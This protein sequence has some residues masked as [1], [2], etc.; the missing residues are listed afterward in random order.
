M[1]TSTSSR[2]PGNG[3]PL[4]PPWADVD[5]AGPGPAPESDRFR[6]FRTALGR[7][8]GSSDP[9][10]L[11]KALRHYTRSS[12]GGSTVGP[13]RFGAMA[14]V[15]GG[16]FGVLDQLRTN[17]A[18]APVDLRALSGRPTREAIDA[19]VEALV[20]ENGDAERIARLEC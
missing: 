8:V 1:G 5:S 6:G 20:P 14:Q 12:T 17:P 7:Y 18:K 9:S 10:Y 3:S 11:T 4:V 16:L 19:I 15:G 13:R 2:G